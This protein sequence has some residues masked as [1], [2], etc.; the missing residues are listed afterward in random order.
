MRCSCRECGTYM[1]QSDAS[2][3]GC[4][5]PNCRAR[6]CDCLGTD[7]VMDRSQILSMKRDTVLAERM[8]ERFKEDSQ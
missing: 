3:L 6:C 2:V 5:C 7:C 8:A 1:V 4:V